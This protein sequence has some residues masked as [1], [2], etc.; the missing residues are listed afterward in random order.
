VE[1]IEKILYAERPHKVLMHPE[2]NVKVLSAMQTYVFVN[3]K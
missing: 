1:R 3:I 2:D